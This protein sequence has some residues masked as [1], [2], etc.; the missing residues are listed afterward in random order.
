[1][2]PVGI[3]YQ[4]LDIEKYV[5]YL[6]GTRIFVIHENFPGTGGAHMVTLRPIEGI[7]LVELNIE[8]PHESQLPSWKVTD[9]HDI[10]LY[11]KNYE[12]L[13]KVHES[14][15]KSGV[16]VGE[17]FD[18]PWGGQFWLKDLLGNYFMFCNE[19]F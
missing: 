4:V 11:C 16:D 6:V 2:K 9:G 8:Q 14:F 13:I 12:M 3:K 15:V 18:R 19:D 10:S 7:T 5:D 17:L 1:M